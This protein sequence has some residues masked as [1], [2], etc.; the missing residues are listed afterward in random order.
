MKKK[1]EF[2]MIEY[3]YELKIIILLII[4]R[5]KYIFILLS[6][7]KHGKD[8]SKIIK[9]F[10]KLLIAIWSCSIVVDDIWEHV[11]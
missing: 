7:V 11:L 9:S 4:K 6:L 8:W 5:K 3:K 1:I 10:G 2:L